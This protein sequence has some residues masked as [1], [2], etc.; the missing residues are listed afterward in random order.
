MIETNLYN[1]KISYYKAI[2]TATIAPVMSALL[3]TLIYCFSPEFIGGPLQYICVLIFLSVFP[4]SAYPLQRFVPYYKH[5]GREGQRSF[6]IFMANS[7]Y[8]CGIIF[9]FSSGATFVIKSLYLTYF[10]SGLLILIF[11]KAFKIKASGHA[12]GIAGPVAFL[13]YLYGLPALLGLFILTAVFVSSVKMGRHTYSELITGS[14]LSVSALILS[15]LI[16]YAPGTIL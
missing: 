12:C 8:I 4:I 6:A 9:A 16:L 7:G 14:F 1:K 5:K 10:L 3:I 13:F 11:N 2:R 15:L